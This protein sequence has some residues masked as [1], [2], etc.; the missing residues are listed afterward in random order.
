MSLARSGMLALVFLSGQ[1]SMLAQ[2]GADNTRIAVFYDASFPVV[3]GMPISRQQLVS[4]LAGR[5]AEFLNADEVQKRLKARDFHTLISPYGSAFPKQAAQVVFDFLRA[6]GNWVNLGGVPLAVPVSRDGKGWRQESR[7]TAYH[8]KLGITQAFSVRTPPIVGYTTELDGAELLFEAFRAE[9]AFGLYIRFTSTKDYPDEDGS[10]GQ[11][12]AVLR[13]LVWG[14]SADGVKRLA[15]FVVIDRLQGEYA[16]GRWVFANFKGTITENAI[17]YL[18]DEA[19]QGPVEFTVRPSFACYRDGET[20]SF[21]VQLKMPSREATRNIVGECEIQVMNDKHEVVQKLTAMFKGGGGDVATREVTMS[22]VTKLPAG[23][24]SVVARQQ[25]K[26][27]G[28]GFL[29]A[30]NGFWVYDGKLMESGPVLSSDGTYFTRNGEPYPVTGTTYMASDVARKFLLTPNAKL[31]DQDFALMKRSGINM[32]RTGIW[33]GW[34]NIMLDVGTLNEGVLRAL[35]AFV[36]TARKHDIPLIFTFFTFIP[37]TWG[38]VNAY[39]D[40]RAV[41]AQRQFL[42][43]VSKRYSA[44]NDLIWDLINEPSFCNPKY[45][46]NCRPNYDKFEIDAWNAWLRARYPAQTE[47]EYRSRMEEKW[48]MTPDESLGLPRLEE[49]S[50][51]NI[52]DERRPLKVVDYRLFAQ[53]MFKTWVGEMTQALRNNGNARQLITVGQDEGGTNDSPNNQFFGDA[54]GFTSLH[55]WWL[56]DDLV[57]DNVMTKF[58]GVPNLVEE[59]GVMFYEKSDGSAWRTEEEAADLLERKL[60]ISFAAGGAGFIEWIWN[61]NPFMK[62]DNEAAIGL[63]R[64]DATAKPEYDR[65]TKYARFFAANKHLMKERRPEEVLMVIPHSNMF[66]TR[67]FATDATK[68]CIRVMSHDFG[69]PV[70]AV[71]EYRMDAVKDTPK[72]VVVPSSGVMAETSW[73]NLL[74]LA[75]KGSTVLLTGPIDAD[76]H[77]LP[78]NR[79]RALGI[80]ATTKTVTQNEPMVVGADTLVARFGNLKIQRIEKSVAADQ[81]ARLMVV[82]QGKGK[83]IWFPLPVENADNIEPTIVLYQ[84]AFEAAGITSGFSVNPPNRGVLILP[85]F[86]GDAILYAFVSESSA[87]EKLTIS[88]GASGSQFEVSVPAQ[89]T[90]LVFLNKKDGTVLSRLE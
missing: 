79:L 72:L 7:Q 32:V 19:V 67:N 10:A 9:E 29:Y 65:L 51:V 21:Q 80:E 8:K 39:L 6:G 57:W 52:F 27:K 18:V 44:V 54:V 48:R 49:F 56:N 61:I 23:L 13:T 14:L 36:L 66:S 43:T 87:D 4:A 60:A 38:G 12:D 63:F 20:P 26:L 22:N 41:H 5:R 88:D 45:L 69:V 71:S 15:P 3:D 58:P 53:E 1:L 70:A 55:N 34:K 76:E 46:W 37:E 81:I 47:D 40:P 17:R 86:F 35:D 89:K 59:T 16:G 85:T 25:K 90:M 75:K 83:I 33:T 64:V 11:R 74:N 82:S 50:D 84:Y 42:Q 68:R 62:S 30:M 78:S 28:A 77:R 73:Q 2:G 31:W 24:Y